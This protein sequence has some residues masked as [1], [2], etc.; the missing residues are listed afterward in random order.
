MRSLRQLLIPAVFCAA[1]LPAAASAQ[2]GVMKACGEK[3]QAAKAAGTAKGTTWTKFLAECRAG[4]PAVPAP[5]AQEASAPA[6]SAAQAPARKEA[7]K[8]PVFPDAVSPKFADQRPSR[9]RQKTCSEQFQANKA[10]GGNAGLRWL[11]RGGGY[12][13]LCNKRLKGA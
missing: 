5:A 6:A 2:D 13:S 10:N 7:G 9:A 12:W 11:E 3:W 4:S 1:F 8:A